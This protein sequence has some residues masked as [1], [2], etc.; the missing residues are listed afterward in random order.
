MV[1]KKILGAVAALAVSLLAYSAPT[2]AAPTSTQPAPA[3]VGHATP[4]KVTAANTRA[5]KSV[6]GLK[7]KPGMRTASKLLTTCPCFNYALGTQSF[8]SGYPTT[9]QGNV[10]VANPYLQ[11][12][13]GNHSLMELAVTHH[14]A[15]GQADT[16][17]IGWTKD[18]SVCTASTTNPCLFVFSWVNG[19]AQGYGT[20]FVNYTGAGASTLHPGDS[21]AAYIGTSRKFG[22]QLDTSTS[23]IWAY[24]DIGWI[25][26]YPLSLWTSGGYSMT[27]WDL[28]QAF[29]E[30]ADVNTA[31]P[32][33]DMGTGDLATTTVGAYWTTLVYNAGVTWN[34][35]WSVQ[36]SGINSEY[37]A[38]AVSTRTG[39]LGGP[40]WNSAGTGVG[41]KGSC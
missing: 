31:T 5:A 33:T 4:P 27:T 10:Y 29:A 25:G 37:N 15:G 40:G 7:G 11:P 26:Y 41:T 23:T 16:I 2:Q 22:W 13:S 19:V 36:P 38:A 6:Q 30:V 39:R 17:E 9:V 21:L 20:G 14:E 18:P 8:T 32:C 12:T 3:A 1:K 24:D 35:A 28:S 34:F